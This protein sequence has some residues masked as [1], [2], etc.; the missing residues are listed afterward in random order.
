MIHVNKV[1]RFNKENT[2]PLILIRFCGVRA[3]PRE[4]KTVGISQQD[5]IQI[6]QV[7]VT[8][9]EYNII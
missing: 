1:I 2:P 3:D 9:T 7:I 4:I 6:F 5:M 8:S